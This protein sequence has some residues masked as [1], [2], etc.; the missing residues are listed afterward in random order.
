[1]E[2]GIRIEE[3]ESGKLVNFIKCATGRS[4]LRVLGGVRINLGDDYKATEGFATA[5][6]IAKAKENK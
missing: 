6:E 3:R 5:Q 1:M 2:H 4:A